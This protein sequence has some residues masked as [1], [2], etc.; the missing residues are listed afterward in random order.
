MSNTVQNIL[1]ERAET[2]INVNTKGNIESETPRPRRSV[3]VFLLYLV[4]H[5]NI[6]RILKLINNFICLLTYLLYL[7]LTYFQISQYKDTVRG[8]LA[9]LRILPSSE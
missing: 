3:R 7:L 6:L 1:D 2:F 9:N 4:E 5:T 8:T